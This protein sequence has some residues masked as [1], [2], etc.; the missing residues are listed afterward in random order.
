[1]IGLSQKER[2]RLMDECADR[3]ETRQVQ[4]VDCGWVGWRYQM[5]DGECPRCCEKREERHED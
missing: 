4:C 1:M 2:D 5:V 3:H